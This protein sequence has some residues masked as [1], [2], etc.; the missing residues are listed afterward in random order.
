MQHTTVILGARTILGGS[1][2]DRRSSQTAAETVSV[3]CDRCAEILTRAAGKPSGVCVIC[4]AAGREPSGSPAGTAE[5]P[6]SLLVGE[7]LCFEAAGEAVLVPLTR[8]RTRLGRDLTADVRFDD[9]TVSRRHALIVRDVDG[10]RVLDDRSLN[11]VFVNGRS[12]ECNQLDHGDEIRIG[13]QRLYYATRKGTDARRR[14]PS[15][16]NAGTCDP[17]PPAVAGRL[18]RLLGTASIQT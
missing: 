4:G 13:R 14:P 5:A 7:C 15:Y 12:V 16:A 18:R 1:Q 6:P 10:V 3:R 11:G 8:E 2:F 17:E 9:P